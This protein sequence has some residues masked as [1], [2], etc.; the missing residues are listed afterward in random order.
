M[1]GRGLHESAGDPDGVVAG[2]PFQATLAARATQAEF[3]GVVVAVRA[4]DINQSYASEL[5]D[6]LRR[7]FGTPPRGVDVRVDPVDWIDAVPAIVDEIRSS[8]DHEH[9]QRLQG[10][11]HRSLWFIDP[12]GVE[13]VDRRVIEGLPHGSE[14]IVNFDENAVRRHAG[15]ELDLLGKKLYG[16]DRWKAAVGQPTGTFARVFAESFPRFAHRNVYPLR[17]SGSQDRFLVHLAASSAA[18][19]PFRR[20]VNA[21]L[22]AGTLIAGK[23]LTGPQKHR[24]VQD[25]AERF[26]PQTLSIDEMYAAGSGFDR[27]QLMSLAQAAHDLGY[28]QFNVRARTVDWFAERSDERTLG[29]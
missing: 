8:R 6:L 16:D 7:Y 5:D 18:V 26:K 9:Q 11:G 17:P 19:A 1:A 23:L 13:P 3:E 20:C 15:K 25:L 22:K 27:Q 4:I 10:H 24:A 12:Y 21:G 2:T 28:G 29:L 14:V